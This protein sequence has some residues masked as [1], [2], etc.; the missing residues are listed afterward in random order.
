MNAAA[1]F[2]HIKV[3]LL[4]FAVHHAQ[5]AFAAL[6]NESLAFVVLGPLGARRHS[7]WSPGF[8]RTGVCRFFLPE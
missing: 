6:F 8:A 1:M 2:E 3:V 5:N 7:L 4:T